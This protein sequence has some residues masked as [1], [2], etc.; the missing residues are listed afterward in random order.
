[1][2]LSDALEAPPPD[3]GTDWSAYR[4]FL[5][6]HGGREAVA[7]TAVE[8][9]ALLKRAESAGKKLYFEESLV[10]EAERAVIS[11]HYVLTPAGPRLSVLTSRD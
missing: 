2:I 3:L 7:E 5:L 11:E 8:N 1:V 9:G 4:S 10:T 6:A